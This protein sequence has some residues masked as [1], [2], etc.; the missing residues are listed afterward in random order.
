MG[1]D[2]EQSYAEEIRLTLYNPRLLSEVPA[3]ELVQIQF[4]ER[5]IVGVQM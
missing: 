3:P 5:V 1:N 4:R 2:V